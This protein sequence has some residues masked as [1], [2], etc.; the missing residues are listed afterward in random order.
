MPKPGVTHARDRVLSDAEIRA[1]WTALGTLPAGVAGQYKIQLLTAARFGEVAA[2]RWA[3]V[4]LSGGW[5]TVPASGSKN[6]LAHRVPLSAPA[7]AIL[8]AQRATVPE[9]AAFVFAG[10]R[11]NDVRA[12]A[13]YG[14]T[15]SRG[16][17]KILRGADGKPIRDIRPHDLRRTAVTRLSAAGVAR[18][19]IKAILNHTDPS[20]T[21]I[22][23]RASHDGPKREALDKWAEMLADILTPPTAATM[24]SN[25]RPFRRG[26]R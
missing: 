19:T 6:G 11:D 12:F 23:D 3:D 22:Y 8:N 20:V 7:L 14:G 18:P 24:P 26:V 21:A 4:D 16:K 13:L 25:V 10:A 9:S 1:V 5:W 15:T 2:M 17:P